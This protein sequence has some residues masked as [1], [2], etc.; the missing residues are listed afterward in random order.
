MS[1]KN[2]K[3]IELLVNFAKSLGQSP[4]PKMVEQVREHYEF[5]K[6]IVDSVKANAAKDLNEAFGQK[7][8]EE[9]EH[10]LVQTHTIEEI[11]SEETVSDS[12]E[13]T[14][15]HSLT[16]RAAKLI[17]EVQSRDSFQQPDPLIV[18]SELDAITKKLRFLEQ[19]I[20][21]M[22]MAGPGGG[23]G[24]VTKLD[25]ETKLI[26]APTYTITSKDYYVGINYSGGVTI[27]LPLIVNNGKV[28]IIKDE[29]GQCA[30]NNI[31][32]LGMV[33]ND[34]GGFILAQNNGSIQ[35]IYRNGWRII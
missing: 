15:E 31:T 6:K 11:I 5:Q 17:T 1:I 34:A 2:I 35:L 22:S 4:D 8:I 30:T 16:E 28:L 25:H 13:L 29:S 23:A 26:A 9:P 32:V 20:G 19:W 10:E 21:K 14:A 27:T 18:P 33:D 7:I 3:E 24:S 12:S